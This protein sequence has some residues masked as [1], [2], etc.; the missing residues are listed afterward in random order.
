MAPSS[1]TYT[2]GKYIRQDDRR[3]EEL[4]FG[5]RG[6][7][8]V[9]HYFPVDGEYVLKVYL[10]RTYQG[11][12]RGLAEPH[13][14]EIR[15]DGRLLGRF[16]VGGPPEPGANRAAGSSP[17]SPAPRRLTP[18]QI[19]ERAARIVEQA[20]FV[21]QLAEQ[22]HSADAHLFV[23]FSAKAGPALLG[24][25][26]VATDTLHEGARRPT[27]M[28]TSYE[29]AGNTVGSPLVASLDVR[30]PYD[31]TGRGDTPSRRRIFT[32]RPAPQSRAE[33]E[34]RCATEILAIAR[35]PRLP[36][37]VGDRRSEAAR[38]SV[39]ERDAATRISTP[40]SSSRS[41]VFSSARPSSSGSSEP[42][43]G[44]RIG[45]TLPDQ[46]SRARVAAVVLPLEQ[47]SR[48]RA[49]GRWRA[50]AS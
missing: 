16:S 1:Q 46:R 33:Q 35:T 43:G 15:L 17:P 21:G 24:A 49:A 31:A 5:S 12:V 25:S 23:R 18:E 38:S 27:L 34:E 30:G 22:D 4:P 37:S 10:D 48:R 40:A 20:Q 32:C 8:A 11:N 29:Y 26:F 47:H 14:L 39:S 3:S 2:V 9:P 45:R 6:G 36:P 28:I 41:S 13:Q 44:E 19:A 7:L 50:R 42:P